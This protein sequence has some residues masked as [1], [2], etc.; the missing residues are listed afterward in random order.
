MKRIKLPRG[1]W[2]RQQVARLVKRVLIVTVV[3]AL[4]GV[5]LWAAWPWLKS[6]GVVPISDDDRRS[7]LYAS[8]N[9]KNA[10]ED[11]L[12]ALAAKEATIK[13]AEPSVKYDYYA[14]KAT[15]LTALERY[16]EAEQAFL[17]A[18]QTGQI[19]ADSK[20]AE[21]FY[22]NFGMMYEAKGD[23]AKAHATYEKARVSIEKM[24]MEADL[25]KIKLEEINELLD[26]T[27]A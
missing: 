4:L 20:I 17:A 6:Q 8:R 11:T 21:A 2:S 23:A 7:P 24:D 1:T 25:K 10:A 26:R 3:V 14:A 19:A 18:E 12:K 13:D 16:D 22:I 9:E 27:K 5:V 15:E